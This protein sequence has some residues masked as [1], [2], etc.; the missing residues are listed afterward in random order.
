MTILTTYHTHM[1]LSK[2]CNP[3]QTMKVCSFQD[4]KYAL[5]L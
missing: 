5:A 3:L 1:L 4:F 2:T